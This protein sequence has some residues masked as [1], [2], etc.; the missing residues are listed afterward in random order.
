MAIFGPLSMR[1]ATATRVSIT[2]PFSP[3]AAAFDFSRKSSSQWRLPFKATL[4][5]DCELAGDIIA[6]HDSSYYAPYAPIY[7]E[8]APT[9]R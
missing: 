3:S 6:N 9:S 5:E 4:T 7:M 2:S 8:E 1:W